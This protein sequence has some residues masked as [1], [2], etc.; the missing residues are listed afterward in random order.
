[1]NKE[2]NTTSKRTAPQKRASI[3]KTWVS[4]FEA[5]D[6]LHQKL[7]GF[8]ETACIIW[9]LT[10]AELE[11]RINAQKA[12]RESGRKLTED[13]KREFG[14]NWTS[15]SYWISPMMESNPALAGFMVLYFVHAVAKEA[16]ASLA[17]H[18][19]LKFNSGDHTAQRPRQKPEGSMVPITVTGVDISSDKQHLILPIKT[20][21]DG[22]LMI[23]VCK[24]LR[25]RLEGVIK[26]V[27]GS[28]E[29]S[30]Q[31]EFADVTVKWRPDMS[32][33]QVSV[34]IKYPIP[35]E[36]TSN[37]IRALD[38][39]S[40]IAVSDSDGN[41]HLIDCRRPDK[42]W[43]PKIKSVE[44]K[45]E[46]CQKGSRRWKRRMNARR[47]M[48]KKSANQIQDFQR[49]LANMLVEI[50]DALTKGVGTII[51]GKGENCGIR[52]GLSKSEDGTAKQHWGAQNTGYLFRLIILIK[53]KA[54]ERGVKVIEVKDPKRIGDIE[55]P[56]SKL[57]ASRQMLSSHMESLGR[58]CPTE[59]VRKPF[60]VS[61]GRGMPP[62]KKA[63]V[64]K[65]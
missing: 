57:H 22:K 43:I 15:L 11:Q 60:H 24:Y 50:A 23:P 1:V 7:I 6:T 37:I 46:V 41:E 36:S 48:H 27:P 28:K 52:L 49:K 26:S 34:A 56:E 12:I 53:N 8:C 44:E 42:Y 20:G 17:S 38:L 35:K 55:D 40:N 63:S 45:T 65:H 32:K 19:E 31:G 18:N 16:V 58:Q 14:I 5:S 29:V 61:A 51:V 2:K 3:Q 25:R 33:W 13:E 10:I 4:Y 9:N 30:S 59:W 54:I 47:K 39:G 62:S 64:L 21:S